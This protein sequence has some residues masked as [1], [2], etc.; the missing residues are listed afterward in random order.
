MRHYKQI[1][2]GYLIAIGTGPGNTEITAE[3]YSQ[4][5]DVIQSKPTPETGYDYLLKEDLIWELVESP[6]NDPV[7]E[8]IT[9][10]DYIA[11]LSEL[12]VIAN[13]EV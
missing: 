9:E 7:D 5:M 8:E 6:E 3:E 10:A 4:I 13:E 12:G 11:A 1:E 2:N